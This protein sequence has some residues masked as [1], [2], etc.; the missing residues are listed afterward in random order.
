MKN[1]FL[2][3]ILIDICDILRTFFI[4][5]A[6]LRNKKTKITPELNSSLNHFLERIKTYSLLV[7]VDKCNP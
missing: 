5:F 4:F 2:M 7:L 1:G 3:V 6:I